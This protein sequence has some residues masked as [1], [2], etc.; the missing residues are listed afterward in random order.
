MVQEEAP[1]LPNGEK[2]PNAGKQKPATLEYWKFLLD[3]T[4]DPKFFTHGGA[5]EGIDALELRA[6]TRKQIEATRGKVGVHA[7]DFEVANRL[8]ACILHPTG[9]HL[10]N[11]T[12]EHNLLDWA[13]LWKN[14]S[15]KPPAVLALP[16]EAPAEPQGAES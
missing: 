2:N 14:I 7:F 10:G 6:L 15:D 11:G 9:G 12:L 1:T 8:Q 3:R 13:L 5:K 4:T 16:E